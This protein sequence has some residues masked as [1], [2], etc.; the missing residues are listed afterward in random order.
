MSCA[1][2]S[3][4]KKDKIAKAIPQTLAPMKKGKQA[5]GSN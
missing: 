2:A 4:K 5:Q 3:E 1:S